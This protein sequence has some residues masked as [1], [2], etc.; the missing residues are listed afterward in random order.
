MMWIKKSKQRKWLMPWVVAV[1]VLG[2]SAQGVWA[3]VVLEV[4]AIERTA[5]VRMEKGAFATVEITNLTDMALAKGRVELRLLNKKKKWA[6]L[7]PKIVYDETLLRDGLEGVRVLVLPGTEVLTEGVAACVTAFQDRGGL[8]VADEHV[9]P[10]IL[11]D[12]LLPS[13]RRSG[14]PERDK[15]V[16]QQRAAVWLG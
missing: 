16:L 3:Q 10:A 11:P 15:A 12:I 5:F 8:V 6:Q 13:Y 9:A 14:D 1:V 4:A 2:V 7:Q